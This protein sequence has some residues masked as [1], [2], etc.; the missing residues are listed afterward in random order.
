MRTRPLRYPFAGFIYDDNF[1][2]I[3]Q[4]ICGSP[5]ESAAQFSGAFW[6]ADFL[7]A[8]CEFF[9]QAAPRRSYA[10]ITE[11][12]HPHRFGAPKWQ[13][14]AGPCHNLLM[15]SLY[16]SRLGRF[17]SLA[18]GLVLPH[19]YSSL[20]GRARESRIIR[21]IGLSSSCLFFGW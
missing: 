19:P 1:P 15:P 4:F 3:N 2:A 17:A 10:R 12:R 13:G 16:C 6:I 21:S 11:H 18:C 20:S 8:G 7:R 5:Y 9:Q 14:N